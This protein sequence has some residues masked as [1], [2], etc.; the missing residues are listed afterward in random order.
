V[1]SGGN[2]YVSDSNNGAIRV[3]Q[4]LTEPLLMFSSTPANQDSSF[5]AGQNNVTFT[6]LVSNASQ[7]AS[8]S[9]TVIVTDIL[10]AGLTPVSMVGTG[11]TCPYSPPAYTCQSTGPVSGGNSYDSLLLTANVSPSAPAQVT[12]QVS[13]W[14]GGSQGFGTADPVFIAPA[15]P[16][17][18]IT[19][20]HAGNFVA[21]HQGIFAIN[22]GNQANAATTSGTVT[23]VDNLP[24]G[25]SLVSLSGAGWSC[26]PNPGNVCT[27]TT[28]LPGGA[29]YNPITGTVNVAS[30]AASPETNNVS[31]SGGGSAS[32]NASDSI[33]IVSLVC[34]VTGDSPVT[35]ADVQLE[36]NEALGANPPANDINQ[37]GVVN[38]IDIQIVINAVLSLGCTT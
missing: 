26:P 19:T 38:A 35:V 24:S 6:I 13:V 1:G 18:A 10:P 16:T 20:T 9:G 11:W 8:T 37:D 28:A 22:V 14:G 36:I 15:V 23:V 31:V 17:L 7:A 27:N 25:M 33:A 21:G 12:N 29:G 30:G 34:A 32:A 5:T 2:L 4:P 3:L